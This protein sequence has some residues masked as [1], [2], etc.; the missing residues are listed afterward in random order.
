[1]LIDSSLNRGR[2]RDNEALKPCGLGRPDRVKAGA[3]KRRHPTSQ[4]RWRRTGG[5]PGQARAGRKG[6][7]PAAYG[8]GGRG[9]ASCILRVAPLP[10]PSLARRSSPPHALIASLMPAPA[11]PPPS[12]HTTT[13]PPPQNSPSVPHTSPRRL[14][15]LQ[16]GLSRR[17]VCSQC[18]VSALNTT[19]KPVP[20]LHCPPQS[21][22]EPLTARHQKT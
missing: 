22:F 9:A 17:S 5:Q 6:E 15:K 21:S 12:P 8:L 16:T 10:C 19:T 7:L 13:F 2:S 20:S 4:R 14:S 11:S 1:M 3:E 18:I